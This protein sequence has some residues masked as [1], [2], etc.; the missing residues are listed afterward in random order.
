MKGLC[1]VLDAACKHGGALLGPLLENLL[2]G[3]HGMVSAKKDKI[4]GQRSSYIGV[5]RLQKKIDI[6]FIS[7]YC[8]IFK[9]FNFTGF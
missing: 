2:S 7:F 9:S 8:Q 6:C 5:R 4:P 3:L 1:R